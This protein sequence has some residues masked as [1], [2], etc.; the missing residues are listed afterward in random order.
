E[1]VQQRDG[2]RT[3]RDDVAEYAAHAGGGPLKGLDRGRMIVRLDLEGDR[4]ALTE[5]DHAGV[6]TRALEDAVAGRRQPAQQG[7]RVLVA[8]VLGPEQREDRELEV[9]QLAS[10]KTRDPVELP[11]RQ[12]ERAVQMLFRNLRQKAS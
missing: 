7:R 4:L 8:A 2:P 3:H 9:V 10:E 6:L 11:V 12:P 5:V 1:A